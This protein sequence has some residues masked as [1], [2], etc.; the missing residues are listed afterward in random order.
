MKKIF[1]INNWGESNEELLKRYS[2]QTPNN[3]GKSQYGAHPD[4]QKLIN[5]T[6][7]EVLKKLSEDKNYLKHQ[8]WA[9][10]HIYT[11]KDDNILL[12]YVFD[13]SELKVNK[14]FKSLV[15]NLL[16]KNNSNR[17]HN[18]YKDYYDDE[19]IKIVSEIYSKDIELFNFN[20]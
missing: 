9:P 3:S 5:L 8:G 2:K 13:V 10:Q 19:T 4:Y 20:F 11:H 15:P 18:N 16:H 7:K 6:F 1:F 17:K 14:N 12:D